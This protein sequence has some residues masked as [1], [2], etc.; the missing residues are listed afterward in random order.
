MCGMNKQHCFMRGRSTAINLFVFTKFLSCKLE[1]GSQV[2]TVY[3]D[4][5]KAFDK[6]SHYILLIKVKRK[7]LGLGLLGLKFLKNLLLISFEI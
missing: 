4:F 1:L 5:L 7:L 3:T 2:D 6:V